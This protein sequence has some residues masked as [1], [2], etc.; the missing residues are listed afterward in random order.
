MDF[1]G[2]SSSHASEMTAQL[3]EQFIWQREEEVVRR[4]SEENQAG[5]SHNLT[6]AAASNRDVA[7]QL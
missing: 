5:R 3:E 1:C 6:A 7:Q 2:S 4:M